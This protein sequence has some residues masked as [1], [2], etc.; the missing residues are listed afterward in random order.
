VGV[1]DEQMQIFLE[2]ER[3]I[4]R[5]FTP[6]DLDL[7][8]ELDSDPEVTRHIP[9]DG[10]NSREVVR[11][12]VLPRWFSLYDRYPGYG[13]FAAI[14]RTTNDFL[15]WFLLRPNAKPLRADGSTREGI[16]VGYRLR[17]PAWGKGY[18]A[19]G[20]RALIQKGFTD[21]G[22]DRIY[23]EALTVHGASRR[24]MEKAGLRYVD[25]HRDGQPGDEHSDVEYALT[26]EEWTASRAG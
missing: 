5:R 7:I 6:D 25:S 2:T 15:G 18:A 13:Y 21:L 19:E 9:G 12:R 22:A 4:L 3:L 17:R 16:E 8:V 20:A 23:A 11:D 26:K 14:E 24:V 10:P 1:H